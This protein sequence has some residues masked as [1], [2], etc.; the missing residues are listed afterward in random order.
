MRAGDRLSAKAAF[1]GDESEKNVPETRQP[2]LREYR[3]I[4]FDLMG[5]PKSWFFWEKKKFREDLCSFRM[6]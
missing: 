6:T 1:I 3:A 4:D 5:S 2:C